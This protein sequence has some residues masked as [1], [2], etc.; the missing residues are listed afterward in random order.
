M[1]IK[2]DETHKINPKASSFEYSIC[3]LLKTDISYSNDSFYQ[4]T[5]FINLAYSKI[6]N[7]R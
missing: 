6:M 7:R 4:S 3:G 2:V 1:A 5:Y